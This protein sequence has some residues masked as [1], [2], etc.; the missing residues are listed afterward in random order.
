MS[1]PYGLSELANNIQLPRVVTEWVEAVR[2]GV[3]L[4]GLVE[5][6]VSP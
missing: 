5:D 4:T 6:L 3:V 2:A 1:Y